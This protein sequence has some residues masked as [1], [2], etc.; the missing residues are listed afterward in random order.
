MQPV[1]NSTKG[2]PMWR[3][4]TGNRVLTRA[5]WACL[6]IG[7][8][9]LFG[10]VTMDL[11]CHCDECET[12]VAVFDRLT[13]EQK[14]LILADVSEALC[15]PDVTW[16]ELTATNEGT[17]AAM[18]NS[19]EFML[20]YEIESKN[21]TRTRRALLAALADDP[22]EEM[23]AEDCTD[24][25][26]WEF[27]IE[28]F[29]DRIL[30]DHDFDMIDDVLD[31]PPEVSEK[32]HVRCQASGTLGHQY[33]E[34]TREDPGQNLSDSSLPRPRFPGAA[35][36]HWYAALAQQIGQRQLQLPPEPGVG[37]SN[38]FEC[39]FAQ[40]TLVIVD[41]SGRPD[42]ALGQCIPPTVG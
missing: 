5:E 15:R 11:E 41:R 21:G 17:I 23:P 25:Q 42:A 26:E 24:E 3:M 9:H 22:P 28:C 8:D 33:Q 37:D 16:P 12:G 7:V 36:A 2:K 29:E 18:F 1:A 14:L 32:H 20:G 13:A 27:M 31:L 40:R 39:I 30:W 4:Q 34:G 35:S 6:S 10:D 38:P 19:L